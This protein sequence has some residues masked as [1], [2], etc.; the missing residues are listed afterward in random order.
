VDTRT[1]G[2]AAA[3]RGLTGAP[4]FEQALTALDTSLFG[5]VRSQTS[6][7][8]RLSLLALHNACRDVH[9]Q[10]SYL[11]VGSYVGGSLQVLVADPRC[12]SITSIDSRP[13]SAPDVRGASDYR[14][15]TTARMLE[16]LGSVPGADLTKV[17]TIEA[18]TGA[19]APDE[20]EAPQLCL[21]DGE[22]TY[23][24]VLGDARFC[25]RVVREQGAI[26]FHDRRLIRPAIERFL[27]EIRGVTH[28]GYA[29]LGQIYVVELGPTRL[30]PAIERVLTGHPEPKPFLADHPD[31]QQP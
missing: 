8:D 30:R 11:E 21:V 16:L 13:A 23:E 4:G 28:E 18:E 3:G 19:I 25:R 5:H 20:L 7:L 1:G 24:G 14:G 9:G 26:A 6:E 10:F 31:R 17:R 29:L 12:V 27:E 2:R 22:H 15:N